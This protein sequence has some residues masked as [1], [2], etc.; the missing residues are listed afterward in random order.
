LAP[1]DK[2][3]IQA[4]VEEQTDDDKSELNKWYDSLKT[5]E[6]GEAWVWHPEKPAIFAKVKFR[7]RETFHA[8]REFIRSPRA[9]KIVLMGV[10]EFVARF[11]KVFESTSDLAGSNPIPVVR[12]APEV[13]ALQAELEEYRSGRKLAESVQQRIDF[14][15]RAKKDLEG[16]YRKM[17]EELKLYDELKSVFRQM[18]PKGIP[19]NPFLT[20]TKEA[21]SVGLQKVTKIVPLQDVSLS[22]PAVR[23]DTVKGKILALASGGFFNNWQSVGDV[24]AKLIEDLRFN[25]SEQAINGALKELVDEHVLG[26]KHTDR[27]RWKL[28]PDVIFEEVKK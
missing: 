22:V 23:T 11:K 5:L 7:S 4:W 16:R 20:T 12:N 10:D 2:K 26:L 19:E 24:S 3:A 15:E 27:N 9:N 13:K 18:F 6:N 28:A 17:E 1:Q 21:Y 8:T 14:L 25:A